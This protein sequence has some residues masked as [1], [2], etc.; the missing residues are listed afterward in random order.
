M[1]STAAHIRSLLKERRPRIFTALNSVHAYGIASRYHL[2]EE[3]LLA[4]R[5]T[6]ERRVSFRTCGEDLRHISGADL[7]RLWQYRIKCT[8]AAK[9][10]ISQMI[11][12]DDAPPL[13]ARCSGLVNIGQYD[14][15]ELQ[16]VPRWWHRH[17]IHRAA[18][19]PSPKIITDRE[20]FE[21]G[22]EV[23]YS[24]TRGCAACLSQD[25]TRL[26]NTICAAVEAK[27]TVAIDLV[28]I[29]A[30]PSRIP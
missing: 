10:C 8:T 6:L 30:P 17:F 12:N 29:G 16:S 7:F 21:T 11:G 9:D 24:L 13:S 5:L 1:D 25:K 15:K 22:L 26:D 19:F 3:A 28:S 18:D 27:L 2:Q 20:A 4:A 23:H 14:T